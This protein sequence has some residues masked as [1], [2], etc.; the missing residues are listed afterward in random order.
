MQ[1]QAEVQKLALEMARL[2]LAERPNLALVLES[3][4]P[5]QAARLVQAELQAVPRPEQ[6]KPPEQE[7]QPE[8]EQQPGQE[9][10]SGQACTETPIS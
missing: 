3:Q 4:E 1:A 8:Q 10:P 6:V 5:G 7:K 2:L 9:K